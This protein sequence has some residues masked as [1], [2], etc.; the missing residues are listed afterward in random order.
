[1]CQVWGCPNPMKRFRSRAPHSPPEE[2]KQLVVR[3][4]REGAGVSEHGIA[5]PA[6]DGGKHVL[7]AEQLHMPDVAGFRE[8]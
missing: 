3:G 8:G 6:N 5:R 1:M 7:E 4:N 2:P